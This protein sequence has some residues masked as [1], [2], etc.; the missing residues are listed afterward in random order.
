MRRL[1]LLPL[2]V[3]GSVLPAAAWADAST[4]GPPTAASEPPAAHAAAASTPEGGSM[5]ILIGNGLAYRGQRYGIA[6]DRVLVIGRARPY[7]ADQHVVVE[8]FR[9][10]HRVLRREVGL[11]RRGDHAEFSLRF[12][13]RQAGYYT[14]KARHPQTDAQ[15][16]FA[17]SSVRVGVVK[18]RARRGASGLKVKLLN[19]ALRRQAYV[20]PGGSR[21]TEATGRAVLAFR[22]VN[23]M[24]RTQSA[25]KAVYSKL[26][27]GK[28][29]FKL[30]HPN[31]GKHVEFDWSR[32]VLV[33]AKGGRAVHIYHASSGKPSTPT[34]FGTFHFYRRQPGTNSHGMVNSF[35][36]YRGYA[37]HGYKEVPNHPASHGC[38]RIPIANSRA[39]YNWISTGDT[40]YVYR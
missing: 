27:R 13:P 14:V 23:G 11:R 40:I 9:S 28:G 17:A 35:Y 22:K 25:N 36:F 4:S 3:V 15:R 6:G 24:S 37:V 12:T 5:R 33:L 8:V 38:I 20:A 26:F 2:L 39:V 16:A 32:Q 1:A 10:G 31:A 19:Y 30:K 29:T 7:V 34:V 18:P 21:F